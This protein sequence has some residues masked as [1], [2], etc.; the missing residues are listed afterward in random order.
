MTVIYWIPEEDWGISPTLSPGGIRS[1]GRIAHGFR[2]IH[3]RYTEGFR[4]EI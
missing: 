4:R 1:M 3:K 2:A